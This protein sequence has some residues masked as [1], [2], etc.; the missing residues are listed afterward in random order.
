MI[1][2]ILHVSDFGLTE[3]EIKL[4]K[5]CLRDSMFH[6][7]TMMSQVMTNNK[8]EANLDP[9]YQRDIIEGSEQVIS[10]LAKIIRK[11]EWAN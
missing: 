10:M 9:D 1:E 5:I 11:L 3:K 8:E 7:E 4:I 6:Y 2:R